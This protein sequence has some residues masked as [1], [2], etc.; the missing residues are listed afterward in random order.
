MI[1]A[2]AASPNDL[3]QQYPGAVDRADDAHQC[4]HREPIPAAAALMMATKKACQSA[5]S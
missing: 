2:V 3:D 4:G 1:M 5:G